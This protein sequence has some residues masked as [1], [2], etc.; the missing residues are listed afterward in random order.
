MFSVSIS[1]SGPVM[2]SDRRGRFRRMGARRLRCADALQGSRRSLCGF[3]SRRNCFNRAILIRLCLD[4]GVVGQQRLVLSKLGRDQDAENGRLAERLAGFEPMQSLDQNE[5][6]SVGPNGNGG[7][8]PDVQDA[9]RDLRDGLGLMVFFCFVE[10]KIF[11]IGKRFRFG[12]NLTPAS[13]GPVGTHAGGCREF[14]KQRARPQGTFGGEGIDE[15][16]KL[17]TNLRLR[18]PQSGKTDSE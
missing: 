6:V 16:R 3:L 5:A 14:R 11:S 4:L 12:H 17:E 7:L 10:T 18:K 2:P 13:T 1:Q 9:F 8:L 15:Q